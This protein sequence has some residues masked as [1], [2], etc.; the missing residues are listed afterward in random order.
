MAVTAYS[1][2][3]KVASEQDAQK[4]ATYNTLH[5]EED[6]EILGML[7]L[8]VAGNVN[9]TLSRAQGLNK[10]FKFTGALTGNIVVFFPVALGCARAFTV[11]NAT[12]GAF[13]LTIKTTVGGSVGPAV[14]QT[15]IVNLFHDGTDVKAR[16]GEV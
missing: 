3:T 15:K 12:T 9:V 13:S 4:V 8:N 6:A 11:W 5:D 16:S 10:I 1:K 7:T 14:T 2:G